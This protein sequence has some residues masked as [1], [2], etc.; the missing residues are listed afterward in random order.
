MVEA[1]DQGGTSFDSLYVNVNGESGY[2]DR[3]LAVYG[4]TGLPCRRCGALGRARALH[5]P[6]VLP[7]PA[8][9]APPAGRAWLTPMADRDRRRPADGDVLAGGRETSGHRRGGGSERRPGRGPAVVDPAGRLVAALVAAGLVALLV[10]RERAAVADHEPDASGAGRAAGWWSWSTARLAGRSRGGLVGGPGAPGRPG[11]GAPTLVPVVGSTGAVGAGRGGGGGRCS[12]STPP[13][14]RTRR[15]RSA[16]PA[17][18]CPAPAGALGTV[19]VDDPAGRWSRWTPPPARCATRRPSPGSPGQGWRAVGLVA[20]P[21]SGR[22]LLIR[23]RLGDGLGLGLGRPPCAR[24][25]GG[26]PAPI[27]PG[28]RRRA[29]RARCEPGRGAGRDADCPGSA[30]PGAG[31]DDH[32][33]PGLPARG[34]LAGPTGASRRS[35]PAGRP[36]AAGPAGCRAAGRTRWRGRWRAA[37][38][39]CWCGGSAGVDL[40]AGLVDDLDGTTYLVVDGAAGAGPDGVSP[41]MA[42]GATG[43]AAGRPR[44]RAGAGRAAGVRAAAERPGRPAASWLSGAVRATRSAQPPM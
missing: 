4:R 36:G 3:E 1:L 21:G 18:S 10:L 35:A 39:P 38:A 8:L 32:P 19:I 24:S 5:E 13:T 2:F 20:V 14:R 9:P 43:P 41:G 17:A 12:A 28:H 16:G 7:L 44:R 27:P 31:G 40:S 25:D 6:V 37:T 23:R 29:P 30:V 15:P 11:L 33:G 26:R 22:S 34:G 42:A